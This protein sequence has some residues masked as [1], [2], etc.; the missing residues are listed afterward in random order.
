MKYITCVCSHPDHVLRIDIDDQVEHGPPEMTFQ[1][2]LNPYH[3]RFKRLVVGV[4]YIL[5]R[6]DNQ[7][8]DVVLKQR[9]VEALHN[10]TTNL[11]KASSE[12]ADKILK[13]SK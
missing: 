1:V 7:W 3:G 4:K 5:G 10:L 6:Y 8:A 12:W 2:R 13:D 11:I 9:Q